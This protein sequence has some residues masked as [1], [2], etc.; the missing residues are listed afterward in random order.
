MI[1]CLS[2]P[3][4]W[5]CQRL[6]SPGWR[7][8]AVLTYDPPTP[9]KNV[10]VAN[11]KL[12]PLC[13]GS[14]GAAQ[15]CRG[16]EGQTSVGEVGLVQC[17]CYLMILICRHMHCHCNRLHCHLMHCH[18]NLSVFISWFCFFILCIVIVINCIVM[19]CMSSSSSYLVLSSYW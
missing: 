10:V 3:T 18:C 6:L 12:K 15:H 16:G 1:R 4:S 7:C 17:H 2:Q 14:Q 9:Q 13:E 8:N 19:L 5:K 11:L